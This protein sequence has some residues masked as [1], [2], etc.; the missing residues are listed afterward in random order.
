M[1]L[2]SRQ[3]EDEFE[4]TPNLKTRALNSNSLSQ[5]L[6]MPSSGLVKKTA[7]RPVLPPSSPLVSTPA[8]TNRAPPLSQQTPIGTIARRPSIST[9]SLPRFSAIKQTQELMRQSRRASRLLSSQP[10]Q[11]E[12]SQEQQPD[13]EVMLLDESSSDL[14]SSDKEGNATITQSQRKRRSAFDYFNKAP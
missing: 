6:F 1:K 7:L 13:D 3:S 14:D 8:W 11:L 12:P 5:P 10:V 9:A 4:D 2:K